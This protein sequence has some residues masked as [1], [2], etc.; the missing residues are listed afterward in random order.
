VQPGLPVEVDD[1][2]TGEYRELDVLDMQDTG[3]GW[4]VEV[5]E[6]EG[7]E[8]RTL[9]MAERGRAGRSSHDP[10]QSSR[11]VTPKSLYPKAYAIRVVGRE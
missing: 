10:V 4:E 1:W 7:G 8:V 9:E 3:S 5:L 11:D 2:S 6:Q